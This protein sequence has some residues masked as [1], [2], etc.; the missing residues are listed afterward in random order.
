[1][2]KLIIEP[3]PHIRSNNSTSQIMLNVI[4]ATVPAMIASVIIFGLRAALMICVC[5]SSCVFFE[6]MFRI[7]FK[8]TQTIGNL[9]AVVTGIL[10]A[11]NLPVT[12]PFYMAVIGC[13]AAIVVVKEMFGG[14]GQ[15]IAN[16]AI[17]GRIVLMLSFP[18]DMS[19]YVGAFYY[20]DG[21]DALATATPLT[22][23]NPDILDLFLGRHGGSIGET[24]SAALLLG[25]VYLLVM[26]IVRPV[27]PIVFAGTVFIGT[28]IIKGDFD[29]AL[30]ALL[31]G[32]LLLG[33]IFMSTD[34]TTNPMTLKGKL[35]F[36]FGCGLITLIIRE[37]GGMPE[38]VAFSI[39][40]MNLITP[41][42]DKI[43]RPK[44]F[45]G[46]KEEKKKERK[47]EV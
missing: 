32:G 6:A 3:S 13:F 12:L 9:S 42:I 11:F 43:T 19:N 44:P 21:A 38:G 4:I 10:L 14:I 27:T 18:L 23:E 17:V 40:T 26:R 5:V 39:L 8:R 15:N 22:V 37:F 16:P 24:C 45:G 20:K 47:E 31:S 28:Y 7:I 41:V 25:F 1:M 30:T 35:I 46:K 2:N 33:A 34:Y 36:A 29:A